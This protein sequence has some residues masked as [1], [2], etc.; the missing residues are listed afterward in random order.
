MVHQKASER[1]LDPRPIL[2]GD[3][4][5]HNVYIRWAI[6]RALVADGYSYKSISN[7]CGFDHCTIMYS[8]KHNMRQAAKLRRQE[9]ANAS[10]LQ[11]V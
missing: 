10:S 6:W 3:K 2:S 1:L 11:A 7:A 5:R 9:K 8:V 4:N